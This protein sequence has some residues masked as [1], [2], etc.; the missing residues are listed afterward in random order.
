MFVIGPAAVD[1]E[2]LVV[3][4]AAHCVGNVARAVSGQ[5]GTEDVTLLEQFPQA[6]AQAMPP[7]FC[8]PMA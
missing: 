7:L 8:D 4:V 3:G 6:G 5:Y 1:D 2:R